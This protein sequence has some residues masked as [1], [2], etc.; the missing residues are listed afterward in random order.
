VGMGLMQTEGIAARCFKAIADES[1]NI[2]MISFG[3]SEVALYFLVK[4]KHLQTA[5]NALHTSFS[6]TQSPRQG[7]QSMKVV[8]RGLMLSCVGF[9]IKYY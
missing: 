7:Q 4:E 5:V 6:L 9:W 8:Q 2:E 1:I 3:P